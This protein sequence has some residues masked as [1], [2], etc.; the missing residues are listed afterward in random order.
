MPIILK[1]TLAGR[2]AFF[3]DE[4]ELSSMIE[5]GR[6]IQCEGYE[7]FE[8]ITEE[9]I[10]QGYRTRNMSALPPAGRKRVRPPKKG[11]KMAEENEVVEDEAVEVAADVAEDAAEGEA[12]ESSDE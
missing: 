4:G 7:I 6:A 3:I 5:D 8:E 9:E 1:N 10:A 11:T 12:S 2:R